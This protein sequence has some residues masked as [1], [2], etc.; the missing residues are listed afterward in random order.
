[1]LLPSYAEEVRVISRTLGLSSHFDKARC[2]LQHSAALIATGPPLPATAH[3]S[4]CLAG[5]LLPP[6]IKVRYD[7]YYANNHHLVT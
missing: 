6:E 5:S 1:M 4:L 3:S 2:H 7:T